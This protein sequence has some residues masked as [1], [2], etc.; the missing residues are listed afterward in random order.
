[1]CRGSIGGGG[2]QYNK[3]KRLAVLQ[4]GE[5]IL[6]TRRSELLVTGLFAALGL[7]DT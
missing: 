3:C 4:Y 6:D 7:R 1:M 5:F 2:I